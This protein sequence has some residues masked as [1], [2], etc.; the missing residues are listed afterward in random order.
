M[1]PK[2]SGQIPV[3]VPQLSPLQ[4]VREFV[5]NTFCPNVRPHPEQNRTVSETLE[6][7]SDHVGS[8][9][10]PNSS[11]FQIDTEFA[12]PLRTVQ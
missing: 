4:K 1:I 3:S 2:H 5:P 10:K 6:S 7:T 12:Q 9:F 8:N 11:L